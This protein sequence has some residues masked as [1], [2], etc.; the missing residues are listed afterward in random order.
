[1]KRLSPMTASESLTRPHL[2]AVDPQTGCWVW[3]RGV[4]SSGYGVV[5]YGGRQHLAHRTFYEHM[6]SAIPS[7]L[8]IDHLCRNRRCVNPGHMD[9]VTPRENTMRGSGQS[10]R[11]ARKTRCKYGHEFSPANTRVYGGVRQCAECCRRRCM[12]S[13]RRRI[14]R[15]DDREVSKMRKGGKK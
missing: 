10:A 8:Q 13:Y 5:C 2:Y 7:G 11:N 1:M 15:I 14:S 6:V 12:E 4:N 9:V 3:A